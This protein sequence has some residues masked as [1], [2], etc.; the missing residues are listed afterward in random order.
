MLPPAH[1]SAT[2]MSRNFREWLHGY[3][4]V[5]RGCARPASLFL[6]CKLKIHCMACGLQLLSL[7]W[8]KAEKSHYV[9]RKHWWKSTR[10]L[11]Q[12]DTKKSSTQK[13]AL[14]VVSHKGSG[15]TT[16]PL[17]WHPQRYMNWSSSRRNGTKKNE[18][19]QNAH[20]DRPVFWLRSEITGCKHP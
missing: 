9:D 11:W 6:S 1:F 17:Q 4:R 2:D 16:T 8:N 12:Y 7:T 5:A 3:Q 14:R 19:C 13:E 15:Q 18:C 20:V 10:I